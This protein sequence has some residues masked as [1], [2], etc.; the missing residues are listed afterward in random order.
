M[1]RYRI[2][3][4][5]LVCVIL[6]C[7]CSDS[8]DTS[9]VATSD[10]NTQS[11]HEQTQNTTDAK[12]GQEALLQ[13]MSVGD[14]W[15]DPG[16]ASIPLDE[17]ISFIGAV[18]G[19]FF[20]SEETD[21]KGP[22]QDI[23]GCRYYFQSSS[24][25]KEILLEIEGYYYAT[26]MIC[27]DT[28][29]FAASLYGDE[30]NNGTTIFRMAEGKPAEVILEQ[31]DFMLPAL[32]DNGDEVIMVVRDKSADGKTSVS[33]LA[34]Y[35]LN[36]K[37]MTFI[38]ETELSKYG[39]GERIICAG[40]TKEDIYYAVKSVKEMRI[41]RYSRTEDRIA[42]ECVSDNSINFITGMD[43]IVVLSQTSDK[44]YLK[45]AGF[46]GILS[47]NDFEKA[48]VIPLITATHPIREAR[49]TEDGL[50]FRA[51]ESAYLLRKDSNLSLYTYNLSAG[52][53]GHAFDVCDSGILLLEDD[54]NIRKVSVRNED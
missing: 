36:T 46:I 15:E 6:A 49:M 8:T 51:L 1:V 23:V 37:E 27:G 26:S 33:R 41:V 30:G 40:G 34:V 13:I 7:G 52:K 24:G 20:F 48:A 54:S 10:N 12:Q 11:F 21:R 17:G 45:D 14:G 5:F 47:E 38:A 9:M 28:L 32:Y 19:G 25:K 22:N 44:E 31:S 18:D 29:I 53:R 50:Y 4:L 3:I 39:N 43:D 16:T 2:G 35:D 42:A